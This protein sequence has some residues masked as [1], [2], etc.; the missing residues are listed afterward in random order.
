MYVHTCKGCC[1]RAPDAVLRQSGLREM[2]PF[3]RRHPRK[4][5]NMSLCAF[6]GLPTGDPG[7]VCGYHTTGHG[8]DWARGNRLMCDLLHRGITSPA[9]HIE[10][11]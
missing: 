7:R 11:R 2:E 4:G 8:E 5:M 6:C 3:L 1:S 10:P 9:P